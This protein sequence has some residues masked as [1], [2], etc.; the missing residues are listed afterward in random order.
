M[1]R[2]QRF[3]LDFFVFFPPFLEPSSCGEF[4]LPLATLSFLC[5]VVTWNCFC[6]LSV[7]DPF[8]L[9]VD[10]RNPL[11]GHTNSALSYTFENLWHY[12]VGLERL[13][14]SQEIDSAESRSV[15]VRQGCC[16]CSS[17][18]YFKAAPELQ[19]MIL[20]HK[21]VKEGQIWS[22]R[23]AELSVEF[24]TETVV[25]GHQGSVCAVRRTCSV[26]FWFLA[27]LKPLVTMQPS[28]STA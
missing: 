1:L 3:S 24:V 11:Y 2:K 23:C 14:K 12:T 25:A 26:G 7:F 9:A 18:F 13:K 6:V 21:I 10:L 8:Q 22:M 16:F 28:S 17:T 15:N 19:S 4:P 5:D 20:F 27:A